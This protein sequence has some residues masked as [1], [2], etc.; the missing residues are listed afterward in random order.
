M[1]RERNVKCVFFFFLKPAFPFFLPVQRRRRWGEGAERVRRPHL[2][3]Q[4]RRRLRREHGQVQEEPQKQDEPPQG[5]ED[6][7]LPQGE[8]QGEDPQLKEEEEEEEEKEE[9][10]H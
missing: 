1:S 5:G 9:E 3:P 6:G 7:E 8:E 2:G 10:A 4:D